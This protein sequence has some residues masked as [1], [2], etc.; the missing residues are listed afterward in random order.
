MEGEE[1]VIAT[2]ISN[3]PVRDEEVP[4]ALTTRFD[5]SVNL[6]Q[7]RLLIDERRRSGCETLESHVAPHKPRAAER[8]FE[9]TRASDGRRLPVDGQ[10]HGASC[11]WEAPILGA[12]DASLSRSPPVS[13]ALGRGRRCHSLRVGHART[14]HRVRHQYRL[15]P[16]KHRSPS[17]MLDAAGERRRERQRRSAAECPSECCMSAARRR[18]TAGTNVRNALARLSEIALL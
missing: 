4:G 11:R 12:D 7:R 6:A 17:S 14:R 13:D 1:C 2:S 3:R 18:I 8:L 10:F 16:Q 9:F 15:A 5:T